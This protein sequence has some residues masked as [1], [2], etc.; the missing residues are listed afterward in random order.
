[1]LH[2]Q[3]KE[4]IDHEERAQPVLSRADLQND[5]SVGAQAAPNLARGP[6]ASVR[7]RGLTRSRVLFTKQHN[8]KAQVWTD[9]PELVKSDVASYDTLSH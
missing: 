1:M 4:C 7:R 6:R 9:K 2:R 5:A 3:A 8:P